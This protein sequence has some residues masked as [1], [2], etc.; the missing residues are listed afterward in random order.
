MRTLARL[1]ELVVPECLVVPRLFDTG[2]L[3]APL[4]RLDTRVFAA[5]IG[6]CSADLRERICTSRAQLDIDVDPAASAPRS[7]CCTAKAALDPDQ[8]DRRARADD[9]SVHHHSRGPSCIRTFSSRS[10]A[11]KRRRER[12]T[13]RSTWRRKRVRN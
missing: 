8:R 7:V 5:G 4:G 9:E 3:I 12:S 13:P 11:A 10:T 6:E 1:V 2:A